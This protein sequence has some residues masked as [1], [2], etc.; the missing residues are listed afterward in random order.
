MHLDYSFNPPLSRKSNDVYSHD[1]MDVITHAANYQWAV[2][3]MPY[4]L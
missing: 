1:I 2:H 3:R 4:S